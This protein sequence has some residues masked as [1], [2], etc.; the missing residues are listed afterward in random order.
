MQKVEFFYLEIE[1]PDFTH[2]QE[3]EFTYYME[4]DCGDD[5][6]DPAGYLDKLDNNPDLKEVNLKLE[7]IR[8]IAFE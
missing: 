7:Q 1:L 6:T 4:G 5:Y 2:P 8:K 3:Q